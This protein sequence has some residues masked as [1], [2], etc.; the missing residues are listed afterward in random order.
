MSKSAIAFIAGLGTGYLTQQEKEK[1]RARQ[2]KKDQQDDEIHAARMDDVKEKKAERTALKDAGATVT[3]TGGFQVDGPNGKEFYSSQAEADAAQGRYTADAQAFGDDAAALGKP[4]G[5]APV[6]A[7]GITGRATGN[8]IAPAGTDVAAM[9]TPQARAG[10]TAAALYGVGKPVE[11]MQIEQGARAAQAA[12]RTEADAIANHLTMKAIREHNGDVFK[13]MA[14]IG[15]KAKGGL[16]GVTVDARPTEDGKTMQIIATKDGKETVFKQYSNDD[17]G[18][19]AALQDM[20]AVDPVT[21]IK[22]FH[23]GFAQQLAAKKDS[24]DERL[25]NST[26]AYQGALGQAAITKADAAETR[27]DGAGSTVKMNEVDKA[28]FNSALKRRDQILK[29]IDDAKSGGTFDPLSASG[30]SMLK[31]LGDVTTKADSL[32]AKYAAGATT[33]DPFGDV[34][35][36]PAAASGIASKPTAAVQTERDK[37]AGAILM[38]EHG[39]DIQKAKAT[40]AELEDEIKRTRGEGKA[41]LQSHLK[42]LNAGIAEASKAPVT[43]IASGGL[44][45]AAAPE[46][47]VAAPA[48]VA[49][50][51]QAAPLDPAVMEPRMLA[52]QAEMGAGKRIQYS[53][54]VKA[55]VAQ[56]KAQKDA[57]ALAESKAYRQREFQKTNAA[58]RGLM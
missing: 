25:A 4:V 40:A 14:S 51:Q 42:R 43:N 47:K 3:G 9:N 45:Q 5:A 18:K 58:S 22:W 21:R 35:P 26:I 16:D 6:A 30:K 49:A 48:P 52:E 12:E 31:S 46:K 13:A 27:A 53:A 29:S 57:A 17:A 23:D 50:P 56:V 20:A 36:K 7:T 37:E 41:I 2:N 39:G 33:A 28:E 38:Q 24:R 8:V 19:K 11:A 44:A 34:R 10:R 54:E 1:D 32:R 55:Y 15:T